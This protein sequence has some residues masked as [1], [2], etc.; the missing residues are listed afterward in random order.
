MTITMFQG[1]SNA[2]RAPNY[3]DTT[4]IVL[5]IEDKAVINAQRKEL[6]GTVNTNIVVFVNR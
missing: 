1:N 4:A 5:P 2:I 3:T 6:H